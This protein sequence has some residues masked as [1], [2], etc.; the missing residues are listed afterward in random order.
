MITV[1]LVLSIVQTVV[2]VGVP[3]VVLLAV[4][5]ARR[6]VLAAGGD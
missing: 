2:L 4:W 5:K 1:V 3:S 6:K